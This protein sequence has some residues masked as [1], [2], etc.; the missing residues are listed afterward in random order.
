MSIQKF[1]KEEL[2]KLNLNLDKVVAICNAVPD[3]EARKMV[4]DTFPRYFVAY[5]GLGVQTTIGDGVVK[6]Q[7]VDP[8]VSKLQELY[9]KNEE[10]YK[11]LQEEDEDYDLN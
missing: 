1:I 9:D 5:P 10:I 2:P 4:L 11:T 8:E 3:E 7:N 6:R